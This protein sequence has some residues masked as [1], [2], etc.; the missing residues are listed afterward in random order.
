MHFQILHSLSVIFRG[1][2]PICQSPDCERL[3][4]VQWQPQQNTAVTV[5]LDALIYT[6]T[7]GMVNFKKTT[8]IGGKKS[9]LQNARN[10]F[11]SYFKRSHFI[12]AKQNEIRSA[13]H[14]L[15]LLEVVPYSGTCPC[16]WTL[17]ILKITFLFDSSFS[18]QFTSAIYPKYVS[19]FL[20]SLRHDGV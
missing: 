12:L 6:E 8:L 4:K 19:S 5:H 13:R 11:V 7:A 18:P 20:Y 3:S 1:N 17:V 9:S 2:C 15:N 16:Q 10:C 14:S